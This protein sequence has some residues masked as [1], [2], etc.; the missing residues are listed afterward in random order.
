MV[1]SACYP[2]GHCIF[3]SSKIN[4]WYGTNGI[5]ICIAMYEGLDAK[6]VWQVLDEVVHV[7]P[8]CGPN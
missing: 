6:V 2:Q 7:F 3:Q 1:Y 8:K 5:D 4:N